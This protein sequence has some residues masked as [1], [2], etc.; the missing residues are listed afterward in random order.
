[1]DRPDRGRDR[2]PA[3]APAR[4]GRL[5]R[6]WPARRLRA[7]DRAQPELDRELRA[8]L[9]RPRPDRGLRR[10][11]RARALRSRL[12]GCP[13]PDRRAGDGD[14]RGRAGRPGL[15]PPPRLVPKCRPRPPTSSPATRSRLSYPL[16]YWNGLGCL[17]AMGMPLLL[18]IAT[19][20]RALAARALA[21]AAL[22]ALA[23]AAL[24]H[25]LA[26]RY[27]GGDR[28]PARLRRLRRRPDPEAGDNGGRGC[29]R[30]DPDRRR[31]PAR[32]ARAG[33][34][35]KRRP[36]AGQRDAGDDARRL[37]RR[38]SA[39]GRDL[40]GRAPRPAAA[41]DRPLAAPK[42]IDPRLARCAGAGGGARRRGSGQALHRW[43]EFKSSIGPADARLA[44]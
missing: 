11:A 39:P 33:P 38:R 12:K 26:R 9:R 41:L 19:S 5:G 10:R 42:R 4:G 21:A 13:A 15:A 6:P 16:N 14:R 22:P 20:A 36:P 37:R 18:G 29:R 2:H 23:L 34:R 1:M 27:R 3:G 24:L 44:R 8:H 40:A 28:R 25:L 30:R 17:V 35:R 31:E 32:R 43:D 7:L